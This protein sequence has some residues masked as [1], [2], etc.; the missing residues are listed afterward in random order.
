MA[1]HQ[2]GHAAHFAPAHGIRLAG[3]REWARAFSADMAGGQVQVD[4][5]GIFIGT[6]YALIQ[7]HAVH[8]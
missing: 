8:A 3:Q 4:Q 7:A 6:M 1:G 5:R 2:V